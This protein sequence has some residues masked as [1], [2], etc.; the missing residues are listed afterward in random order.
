[1]PPLLIHIG[2]QPADGAYDPYCCNYQSDGSWG[3][4]PSPTPDPVKW[5]NRACVSAETLAT[6]A[7]KYYG[8]DIEW[9]N[10][11]HERVYN[12]L[13]NGHPVVALVKIELSTRGFG[14]FVTIRGFVDGGWTAVFNDSYPVGYSS[15]E[16]RRQAGEGRQA[17]W[18]RFDRSWSSAVDAGMDPLSPDGHVRW[19]MSIR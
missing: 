19:A 7:Q 6:V 18:E 10:W 1:M 11:T 2:L 5:C 15:E 14:H 17:D 8:L 9:D 12:K 13:A 4:I 3:T 16:A